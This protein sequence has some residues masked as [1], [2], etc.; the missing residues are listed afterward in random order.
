MRDGRSES[1]SRNHKANSGRTIAL[2]KV[3]CNIVKAA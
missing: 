1:G 3:L 2:L